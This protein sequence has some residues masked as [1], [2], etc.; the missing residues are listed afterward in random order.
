MQPE[1]TNE[2]IARQLDRVAELLDAQ[3]ANPFRVRAYRMAAATL[4]A[5]DRP[6]CDILAT[7][8]I[9]GLRRVPTIGESLAR[10]IAELVSTGNIELLEQLRGDVGPEQVFATIPGIGPVL[11]ARI[12]EQLGIETLADLEAA[13]YDG[14]LDRVPGFGPSRIRGVRETLAGRFR[15]SYAPEGIAARPQMGQPPVSELLDVDREYRR[16]AATKTLARI[17]P[18]RYNPTGAA[19]LPVLHTTRGSAHYTA[20][21]S[22]TPRAHELGMTHDWVVIYRDD[23]DGSGRWTV[24][25]ARYGALRGR[26]IVRGREAECE[27]YYAALPEAPRDLNI[28]PAR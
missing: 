6:V 22:N 3:A 16:R 24:I 15:R 21:F 2:E 27:A 12:H 28:A 13:A 18:R 10:S 1:L 19:W 17:A 14:R 5:L 23:Q 25:T 7:E 4:R 9:D 11:A 8:G 20:L 26:R